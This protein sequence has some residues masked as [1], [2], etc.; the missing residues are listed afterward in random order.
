MSSNHDLERALAAILTVSNLGFSIY[1]T[2]AGIELPGCGPLRI[3]PGVDADLKRWLQEMLA[4]GLSE[5]ESEDAVEQ[6]FES[7]LRQL[8]E[9]GLLRRAH[10]VW[11]DLAPAI[12]LLREELASHV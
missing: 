5:G 9:D 11:P 8:R 12:A 3:Q 2:P 7:W 4:D 10:L 6:E 1:V